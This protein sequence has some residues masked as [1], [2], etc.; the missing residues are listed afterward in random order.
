MGRVLP[1]PV[2]SR[3]PRGRSALTTVT[4]KRHPK[5]GEYSPISRALL[6]GPDYQRLS[7]IARHVFLTLKVSFGP[8][9][10]EVQYPDALVSTL[11][12]TTGWTATDVIAALQQ[13]EESGWIARELNLLWI[14]GQL[15]FHPGMVASNEMH[16]KGIVAHVAGLPRLVIVRR[17][18][19]HYAPFFCDAPGVLD[20]YPRIPPASPVALTLVPTVP[21]V[22][23]GHAIAPAV[24]TDSLP[25]HAVPKPNTQTHTQEPKTS[26][27][28]DAGT[29]ESKVDISLVAFAEMWALYPRRKGTNSRQAAEKC[30]KA[31]IKEGESTDVMIAGVTQYAAH[32]VAEGKVGT[33]FVMQASTFLGPA[34]HYLNLEGFSTDEGPKPEITLP[35]GSGFTAY[36]DEMTSA[37]PNPK[38]VARLLAEWRQSPD[39]RRAMAEWQANRS[40]GAGRVP[41][42]QSASTTQ[43]AAAFGGGQS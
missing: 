11:A 36:G 2:R 26:C 25:N 1:P 30:W 43:Y 37:N 16:R 6:D 9:G 7:P 20:A 42:K 22:S 28:A 31:R 41:T 21:M 12:H 39:G 35:D 17:F 14:I 24:A 19:E 40:N 15:Q 4:E 10:I 38:K 32:C 23:E 34:K 27:A 13:L 29:R 5:R 8:S 33:P 18:I 3:S